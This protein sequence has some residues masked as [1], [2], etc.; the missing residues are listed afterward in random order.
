VIIYII[1]I[2]YGACF[3]GPKFYAEST[4]VID[5]RMRLSIMVDSSR[6]SETHMLFQ[7]I[8]MLLILKQTWLKAI[9]MLMIQL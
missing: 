9:N 5:Q 8:M 3:Y 7:K 1:L 2:A 6:I 4:Y